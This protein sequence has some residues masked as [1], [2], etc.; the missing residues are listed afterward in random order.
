MEAKLL[1][2]LSGVIET[3]IERAHARPLRQPD[4]PEQYDCILDLAL[5]NAEWGPSQIVSA[6]KATQHRLLQVNVRETLSRYRMLRADGRN[7]CLQLRE[8]H[9]SNLKQLTDS[10][11]SNETTSAYQSLREYLTD[12]SRH[13]SGTAVARL[14]LR[15]LAHDLTA[16]PNSP[17]KDVGRRLSKLLN[18]TYLRTSRRLLRDIV[19][20]SAR[21]KGLNKR[22][23]IDD[24][25]Q[26]L[27]QAVEEVASD[28][29][30][31]G[32]QE[33]SVSLEEENADLKAALFG[34]KHELKDLS[35]RIQN[36]QNTARADA[37][38]LFFSEM[39]SPARGYLLDNVIRSG[40][41]VN[42]LLVQG[43]HPELPEVE[44]VIY[45][46]KM[47]SDFFV[48]LGLTPIHE[49]GTHCRI[50]LS[51]L[52]TISYS[53]S[54]FAGPQETKFVEIR[55]PG[56][57]LGDRLITKPQ[58]VEIVRSSEDAQNHT[59]AT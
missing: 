12:R 21:C 18:S 26:D 31:D 37:A 2:A 20:V 9:S 52:S 48:N 58:A 49:I 44:G 24:A 27:L 29:P 11:S 50:A 56:W 23:S 28:E 32:H 16:S 10:A 35:S 30:D 47:L 22:Q 39:N 55:T 36:I 1:E 42:N 8:I 38:A 59:G 53:G 41:V 43:W 33:E 7:E 51:D 54:E 13:Q 46:L 3:N 40:H 5:A 34:L 4:S 6:Y 45:S 57:R 14:V 25:V 17:D 15:D 19:E